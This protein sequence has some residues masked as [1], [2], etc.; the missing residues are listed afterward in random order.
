VEPVAYAATIVGRFQT[1]ML[2]NWAAAVEHMRDEC[3]SKCKVLGRKAQDMSGK[4]AE[5]ATWG[6]GVLGH[7]VS[8]YIWHSL[9]AA[10]IIEDIM[11]RSGRQPD[12]DA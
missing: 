3:K 11:L 6:R 9:F 2:F 4:A 5:A 7:L 10:R 1:F 8:D 12:S